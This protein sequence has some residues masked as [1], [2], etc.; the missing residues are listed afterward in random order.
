MVIFAFELRKLN[1]FSIYI[2]SLHCYINNNLLC[3]WK[4]NSDFLNLEV[5]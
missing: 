2:V 4:Y 5:S 3:F 1:V